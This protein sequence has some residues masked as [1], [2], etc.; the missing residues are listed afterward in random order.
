MAALAAMSRNLEALRDAVAEAAGVGAGLWLSYLGV[1]FYLAIAVGSVTHRDLFFESPLRLPLLNVD[2]PLKAFFTL[3]PLLFLIVHAYVLLHFLLLAGKIGALQAEL[4]QV[5]DHDERTR[6]RRRL[7][8]N[9]FVQFLAGPCEVRTR[10]VGF[11]LRLI[12]WITLVIGPIA[13]LVLFQLQFLPYHHEPLTWW[14]RAAVGV[15]LALLWALWPSVARGATTWI[16]WR[17]LLRG[18]V[19]AA[20]LASL[21]PVLL[22]FTIATFPGELLNRYIPSLPFVPTT[23]PSLKLKGASFWESMEWTSPSRLLLWGDIDVYARRPKSLWSNRLVLPAID[24]VDRAKFD[25]ETK[26][27]AVRATL[28]LR[29]RRLESAILVE[30][31]LRKV[32]FE[33]AQ[34]QGASLYRAQLQG[35][36]LVEAR[37]Q[38]ALL[39]RAQLQDASLENAKLQGASLDA[40]ELQGAKLVAAGLQGAS[41]NSARLQGASLIGA[42]LQG[43]SLIGAELQGASLDGAQLQGASLDHAQLQGASLDSAQLQGASFH[44]VFVWRADVRQ[45]IA[46]GTRVIEPV[47]GAKHRGAEWSA[48]TFLALQGQIRQRLPEGSFR[49]EAVQRIDNA[50]QRIA[51]LEPAK[52]VDEKSMAKRWGELA[53]SSPSDDVYLKTLAEI[54]C[55]ADTAY[56]AHGL[57]WNAFARRATGPGAAALA[58]VFLDEDRCA[59]VRGRGLSEED[60]AKLRRIRD[61]AASA[62]PSPAPPRLRRP[63]PHQRG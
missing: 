51:I 39:D 26:I 56:V 50:L 38:G 36:S 31:D 48:K 10:L 8:T 2:L 4:R 32:D 60:R 19:T 35:A 18:K 34:M 9:I 17:D 15:D 49:D 53:Q 58:R 41:L 61:T 27:A 47:T 62:P 46:E 55:K 25:T 12:A 14:H 1:F 44:H 20:A 28:S 43:A 63:R 3:G 22:V 7:P 29:G 37:L 24:A 42:E 23:W 13:L 57:V 45:A 54:G 5:A 21:L 16:T 6:L 52:P 30:A 33:G 11:L 40:A 59:G